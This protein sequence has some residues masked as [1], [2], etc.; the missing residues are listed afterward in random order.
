VAAGP[1]Q[2]VLLDVVPSHLLA[3]SGL[4][5]TGPLPLSSAAYLS[6]EQAAGQ[7]PDARSDIYSLGVILFQLISGRLPMTGINA[8]E[9]IEAHRAH[10]PLRL[11]DVG[12]KVHADLESLVAR[13]M[14]KDPAER[15]ASGDEVSVLMRA[16][17]PIADVTPMEDGPEAI[18][19]PVPVVEG[20]RLDP[21]VMPPPQMLPPPFDPA[22]ERAM[23]GEVI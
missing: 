10:P 7:P 19:D 22:L 12:K 3:K 16:M 9:L 11:R 4:P 1:E 5:D 18:E 17:A 6:P 20:P 23:M 2:A 13:L 15:P 8:D 21:E 14:S